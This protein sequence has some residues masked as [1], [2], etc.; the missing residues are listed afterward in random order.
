MQT[1]TDASKK[2][3]GQLNSGAKEASDVIGKTM[4]SLE[5]ASNDFG[6]QAGQMVSRISETS[7]DYYKTS[8]DYVKSHP[9]KGV[10]I[11]AGAGLL[12]GSLLSAALR[13]KQ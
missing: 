3:N 7:K 2:M 13:R 6:R 9:V 12:V 8:E 11:A 5:T 1:A 4:G 10:A